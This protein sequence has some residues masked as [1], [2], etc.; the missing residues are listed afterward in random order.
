MASTT[1]AAGR[2][3]V[4]FIT[5]N[6]NKLSE[7]RAILEPM[8]E[9]Q[10][11]ELDLIEIQGTVE[12]VTLDKCRRAVEQVRTQ[13]VRTKSRVGVDKFGFQVQGPV[14]VEDTCLCFNAL[15]GLPGPYM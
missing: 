8:I 4:N 2:P 3:I 7:V 5:G 15:G 9:V 1:N 13:N 14:L 12:E 11:Q 6:K 10:S